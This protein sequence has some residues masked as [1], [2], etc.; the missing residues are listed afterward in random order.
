M[1][2]VLLTC[3]MMSL[4]FATIIQTHG[5]ESANISN[6]TN[7][8]A[9]QNRIV[10]EV[11][12][13]DLSAGRI[14][15]KT[16]NGNL[17]TLML[18]DK[19]TYLRVPPGETTMEKAEK[20]ALGDINIGDRLLV[21]AN[22]AE[23][24]KPVT[25]RQLVVMSK[26]AIA[27]QQGRD[28]VGRITAL[29]SK[30]KEITVQRRSQEGV[31]TIII[32][33]SGNVRFSRYAPDSIKRSDVVP[34]SFAEL[35]VGNLLRSTGERSAD[36]K[37]FTAEEIIAGSFL[38]AGGAVTSINT[39]SGEVTIKNTQT[40]RPLTIVISKR[41][42][43]RRIPPDV[44][45][46]LEQGKQP[47]GKSFQ[48]ILEGLPVITLADLKKGDTVLVTSTTSKDTSKVTAIM[49]FTGEETFMARWLQAQPR[50]QLDMSPGLPGNVLGGGT[51]QQDPP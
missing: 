19:T 27:Q 14:I 40:G 43:L 36:G 20:I 35:K 41:S 45:K 28:L 29:D 21:F 16:D 48:E 3:V 37:Q 4:A 50:D 44:A 32:K 24:G 17:V 30:K 8:R 18:D 49:L 13:I 9:L 2:K 5:V 26:A 22:A 12:T 39:A 31:E 11:T 7:S 1:K 33:A 34:S 6:K 25:V 38:R 15:V 42:T 47:G 46:S 10:G 51:G 23:S